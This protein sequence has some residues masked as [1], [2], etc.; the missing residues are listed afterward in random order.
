MR[1]VP[2]IPRGSPPVLWT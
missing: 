2:V 1:V